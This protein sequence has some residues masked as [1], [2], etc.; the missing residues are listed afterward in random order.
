MS[1]PQAKGLNIVFNKEYLCTALLK[2]WGMEEMSAD[3]YTIIIESSFRTA[4][5]S[6]VGKLHSAGLRSDKMKRDR[7]VFMQEK[8]D[9][10]A[11]LGGSLKGSDILAVH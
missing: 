11:S 2:V 7:N 1:S 6:V 3:V 5:Y 10:D 9:T 8:L 4:V